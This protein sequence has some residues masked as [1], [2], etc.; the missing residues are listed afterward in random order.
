MR[1]ETVEASKP[2]KRRSR[3]VEVEGRKFRL[4]PYWHYLGA[5]EDGTYAGYHRFQGRTSKDASL[6]SVMVSPRSLD[7]PRCDV[8]RGGGVNGDAMIAEAVETKH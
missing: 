7:D 8:I 3:I 6:D 4:R 5:I 1:H 2:T